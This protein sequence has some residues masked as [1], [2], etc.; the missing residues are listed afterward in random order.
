VVIYP[1]EAQTSHKRT[2][3]ILCYAYDK[4]LI[5]VYDFYCARYENIRFKDFLDLGIS[6]I[7]MKIASVPENEPLFNIL[8]SR[9]INP[10]KIKNKDER[11]HWIKLKEENKIPDIYIP[12]EELDMNLNNKLGGL[13]DGKRFM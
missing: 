1:A 7:Q 3:T 2:P 5:Q 6:E 9:V 8:K 12:N 11:H 10:A 13:K 4:D